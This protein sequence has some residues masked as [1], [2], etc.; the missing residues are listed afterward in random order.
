M[1]HIL[2]KEHL[3]RQRLSP[4]ASNQVKRQPQGHPDN[5]KHPDLLRER[6]LL[7]AKQRREEIERQHEAL[8]IAKQQ[9]ELEFER[10]LEEQEILRL[11]TDRL[12]KEQAFR[13][14]QLEEEN[15]KKLAE[16]TLIELE[17][18]GDWSDSQSEFL[19]T[20]SQLAAWTKLT[21]RSVSASGL[22]IHP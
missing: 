20:V 11:R 14:E 7:I 4:S 22:K 15:R 8:R 18:T 9:Q 17:L 3:N 5:R 16:A 2:T 21:I 1:E 10:L 19:D 6:D 13:V 12:K